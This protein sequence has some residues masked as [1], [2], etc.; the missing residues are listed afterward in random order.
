MFYGLFNEYTML[1]FP[2]FLKLREKK[3]KEE[4]INFAGIDHRRQLPSP[5]SFAVWLQTSFLKA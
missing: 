5:S 1:Y 3:E 4:G 2:I